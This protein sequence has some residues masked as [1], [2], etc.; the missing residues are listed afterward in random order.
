M[1]MTEFDLHYVKN[2]SKLI[3]CLRE[4]EEDQEATLA[5][6]QGLNLLQ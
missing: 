2:V 6:A 3:R 1:T 5:E 4:A